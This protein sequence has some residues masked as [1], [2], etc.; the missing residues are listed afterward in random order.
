MIG[1]SPSLSRRLSDELIDIANHCKVPYQIE[2]MS[3][4]TSTNADQFSVNRCGAE[5]STLS[6]P[7]RYMHTS[8]E[9]VNIDD[10]KYTGQLLAEFLKGDIA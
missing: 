9:V 4:L 1:V 6:I 8:V 2:V 10:V 3:G 7:L 5:A